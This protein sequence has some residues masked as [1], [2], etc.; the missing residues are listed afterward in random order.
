MD[1]SGWVGAVESTHAPTP[2]AA[3]RDKQTFFITSTVTAEHGIKD[4]AGDET[5]FAEGRNYLEDNDVHTTTTPG[6]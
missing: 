1:A 4:V 3:R 2:S 6:A 5:T